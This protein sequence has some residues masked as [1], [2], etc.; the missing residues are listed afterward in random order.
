MGCFRADSAATT[1]FA[2]APGL[3][4]G[5]GTQSLSLIPNRDGQPL[6]RVLID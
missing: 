1:D 4:Q 5:R 3:T 2:S 6:G